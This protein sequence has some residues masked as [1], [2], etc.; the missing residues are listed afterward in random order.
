MAGSKTDPKQIL[1]DK[2]DMFCREYVLLMDKSAAY[3]KAYDASKMTINSVNQ[4][5]FQLFKKDKIRS[6]IAALKEEIEDVLKLSK[7][8]LVK[9]LLDLAEKSELDDGKMAF[10]YH[11]NSIK[12]K[13]QISKMMGYD[14]PEKKDI[15]SNGETIKTVIVE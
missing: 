14:A 11:E 15:T 10:K 1:T 4:K 7:I 12:A 2:E 8:K 5:A 3:R 9:S 6:R 13:T